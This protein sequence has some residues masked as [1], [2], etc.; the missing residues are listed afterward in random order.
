[1]TNSTSPRIAFFTIAPGHEGRIGEEILAQVRALVARGDLRPGDR[2]PPERDLALQLGVSRPSVRAALRSLVA[3][4]LLVAR[5]GSGTYVTD[6]PPALV[7]EPLALLAALHGF[8]L[9]EIF[10]ARRSLES[11]LAG[12]AAERA[13]GEHLVEMAEEIA[14]MY[15]SLGDPRQFLLHDIGFHKAIA[16]AS[17]SPVLAT[18]AEMV[19]AMHYERR[20]ET[21]GRARDLE[22]RAGEHRRIF[23]AIRK[24]SA[25]EARR[26]MAEHILH[27]QE[28]FAA[29][30]RALAERGEGAAPA[31]RPG[32]R[33]P[34]G[35]RRNG[36]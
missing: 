21:I 30:E 1:M 12:M 33:T 8:T 34:R 31:E 19:S 29:E 2:L 35:A 28:T 17:G 9:D 3:M 24:G 20:R 36:R 18:V 13:T 16:R 10:E 4:G 32:R 27:A 14:N 22:Q 23:A 25:D 11:L 5:R 7:S 26:T 6:G 15:A